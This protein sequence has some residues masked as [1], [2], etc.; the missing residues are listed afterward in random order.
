MPEYRILSGHK[1]WT[2]TITGIFFNLAIKIAGIVFVIGEFAYT[3]IKSYFWLANKKGKPFM[4]YD[5]RES[6]IKELRFVD[7]IVEFDDYDGSS[8]DAIHELLKKYKKASIIFCNGGDRKKEN[9][10][11]ADIFADEKRVVFKDGVGGTDK[12]NSSSWIVLEYME[13]KK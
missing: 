10:P 11:E 5:E 4:P 2:Q 3:N 1:S 8:S 12:I 13:G 9:I 7:G 6:I